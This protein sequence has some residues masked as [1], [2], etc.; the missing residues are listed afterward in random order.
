[1]ND[2]SVKLTWTRTIGSYVLTTM[3]VAAAPSRSQGGTLMAVGSMTCVQLGLALLAGLA[4]LGQVPR[5]WSLAGVAFVV[6][7]GVGAVRTGARPGT[8]A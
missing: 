2:M 4:L 5:A 3:I 7:A 1:M 6:A 8:E